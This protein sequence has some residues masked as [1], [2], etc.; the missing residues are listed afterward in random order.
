V[1]LWSEIAGYN[2]RDAAVDGR[3]FVPLCEAL[4]DRVSFVIINSTI[5]DAKT[6][7][8]ISRESDVPLSSVYRKVRKLERLGIIQSRVSADKSGKKIAYYTCRVKAL[9]MSISKDGARLWLR[10]NTG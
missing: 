5:R 10:A 3:L 8:E 7:I 2:E 9:K 4:G 6:A 1:T